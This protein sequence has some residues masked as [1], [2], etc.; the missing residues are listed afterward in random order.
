MVY[1]VYGTGESH[2]SV[3]YEVETFRNTLET[4][5]KDKRMSNEFENV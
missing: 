4:F 2:I 1:A 5:Q 3:W